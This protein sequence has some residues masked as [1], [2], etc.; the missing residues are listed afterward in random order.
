MIIIIALWFI[1]VYSFDIVLIKGVIKRVKGDVQL[2][3]KELT[4]SVKRFLENRSLNIAHKAYFLTVSGLVGGNVICSFVRGVLKVKRGDNMY[5]LDL[6][7]DNSIPVWAVL[8]ITLLITIGHIWFLN[9]RG[10]RYRTDFI[11]NA[12]AIINT[13]FSFVP[14]QDWF[15]QKTEKASKI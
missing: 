5:T 7:Y 3:K 10:K 1:I 6:L 2:N 12:A 15:R 11:S 13:E 9:I 8:I 4:D 14:N